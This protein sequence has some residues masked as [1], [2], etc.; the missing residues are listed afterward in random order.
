MRP[1]NARPR[2]GSPTRFLLLGTSAI[3]LGLVATVGTLFLFGAGPFAAKRHVSHPGMIAVPRSLRTIPAYTVVTPEDVTDQD[4]DMYFPSRE[5]IPKA[6][7]TDRRQIYFR[8]TSRQKE[9][10]YLF[11]EADFAPKGTRPGAVAGVPEGKRAMTLEADKL[12]GVYGL[13]LGDHVDLVATIPLDKLSSFGGA[14]WSRLATSAQ[15]QAVPRDDK[16][17]ESRTETR[18]LARDAV[19]VT[20]VTTRTRSITSSSLTQGTTVRQ[21]PVHEIVLAVDEDEVAPLTDAMGLAVA[22]TCVAHSGRPEDKNLH[23]VPPGMVA[24][25]VNGRAVAAYSLLMPEDLLDPGTRA[26]RYITLN[27]EEVRQRGI[28]VDPKTVVGRVLAR[29]KSRG[30]FFSEDDFLPRGTAPGLAGGIPPGKRALTLDASKVIGARALR[31]GDHFDLMASTPIDW[32]KTS[33]QGGSIHLMGTSLQKQAA[34]SAVVQ[35]GVV[36]MPVASPTMAAIEAASG[37]SKQTGREMVVAVAADEV[38]HVAEALALGLELTTVVRSGNPRDSSKNV[39]TPD[40]NPLA[41][42]QA[43]ESIVGHKRETLVFQAAP[44]AVAEAIRGGSNHV[45]VKPAAGRA[46]AAE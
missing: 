14:D 41:R 29:D 22:I 38:A 39:A 42:V 5:Q 26:P 9:P 17:K 27:A 46:E 10:G 37:D 7:I 11:S 4:T 16:T 31:L 1:I 12:N 18:M 21:V 28:V 13:Q 45:L 15:A 32:T 6:V 33:G 19:L 43:I 2:R 35:D 36:V 20:P 24:V 25:P 34:V 23:A 30:Q 3:V 44:A 8:V 40:E